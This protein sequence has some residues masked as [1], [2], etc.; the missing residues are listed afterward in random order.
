M[1]KKCLWLNLCINSPFGIFTPQ[2]RKENTL[3]SVCPDFLVTVE[4]LNKAWDKIQKRERQQ[5]KL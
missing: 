4:T 2:I 5:T 1:D 3:F